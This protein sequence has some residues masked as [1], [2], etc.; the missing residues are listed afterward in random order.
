MRKITTLFLSLALAAAFATPALAVNLLSDF[1]SYPDGNLTP[2]GGWASFSGVGTDVQV[3]LGRATG[4]GP[5][6][7]DDHVFFAA[8]PATASTYACFNVRIPAVAAAPK[9]IYFFAMK[10]GGTAAFSA[11]VY[12]LPITG[13]FTFGISHSSTSATV[14]VTPWS[15]ASLNYDQIY[16]IVT[17]YDP[18]AKTSTLWVDPASEAST[19]VT[20]A[21]AAAISISVSTVAWRQSASA[22]T[23]PASPSYAGTAD[24]GFSADNLGVGTSFADACVSDPTPNRGSTWGQ[25]KTL[26]R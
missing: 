19:S 22:S 9:P 16:T 17:K 5:N 1:F 14:G 26:Y 13:G 4:F 8:Q 18:V 11:R 6:A 10:D 7:V 24:W 2:N 20:D 23:L 21:N 25:I 15:A 3:S 12:V